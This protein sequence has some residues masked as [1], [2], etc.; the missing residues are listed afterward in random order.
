MIRACDEIVD[1]LAAG[2]SPR[3][4][5]TFRPSAAARE[6]AEELIAREKAGA[7][8]DE[9]SGELNA[10]LVLEHL[11]RLAKARARAHVSDE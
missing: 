7:L 2:M 9:E 8:T 4:L 11:M 3:D 1:F 5:I 6:R 10:Y